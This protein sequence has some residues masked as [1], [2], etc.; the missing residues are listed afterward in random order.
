MQTEQTMFYLVRL[1]RDADGNLVETPLPDAG[2]FDKGADAAK[3]SKTVAAQSGLKVQCRR[4]AQAGDWRPLMQKRLESGELTLLPTK[5]NLDP[6][7]DHFAHLATI[8]NSKIGFIEND[9]NGIIQKITVLT[10]GRYISR[11]YE[12]DDRKMVDANRRKLIAAIDPSGEVFFA[13]TPEEIEHVYKTGPDSCMDGKH[14]FDDLSCWP[15]A[16]YGAGDLAVAYTKNSKGRIQSRTLCWPDKKVHG[17]CYGDIERMRAAMA[18]EGYTDLREGK[19]EK[20]NPFIGARLLKVPH[21][22]DEYEYVIPY[23]DDINVAIDMGDYFVTAQAGQ[24]GQMWVCSGGSSSG[25][26]QLMTLCPRIQIAVQ[27]SEM[28]WVHGVEEK[29]SHS[30]IR[31]HGFVCAGSGKTWS[32]DCRIVLGDGKHWS[33]EWFAEHGANCAATG[34]AWPKSVMV[35]KGDKWLHNHS[36][37]DYDDAG[38]KI[39]RVVKPRSRISR[40]DI[41]TKFDRAADRDRTAVSRITGNSVDGW[42]VDDVHFAP[43]P[44][45]ATPTSLILNRSR[46]VA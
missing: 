18:A 29:W 41:L 35:Q 19:N 22:E 34:K 20:V 45:V 36:A 3:A 28:R 43:D 1:D 5:W 14:E 25:T 15:T 16:P 37:D 12:S 40:E 30:A 4:K 6:I 10:P 23:F 11:F 17:R 21:D 32:R 33:K 31:D 7:K 13:T 38:N 24:E 8:D 39:E 42:I 2:T 27:A 9:D 46:R 26:A 44:S